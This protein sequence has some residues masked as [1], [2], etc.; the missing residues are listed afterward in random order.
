MR[1][2]WDWAVPRL[3]PPDGARCRFFYCQRGPPFR[4][5]ATTESPPSSL[6]HRGPAYP[7]PRQPREMAQSSLQ[8]GVN[9]WIGADPGARQ[10]R[11]ALDS[12]EGLALSDP[13]AFR[14]PPF[15]PF[16]PSACPGTRDPSPLLHSPRGPR[17]PVASPQKSALG[18][19]CAVLFASDPPFSITSSSPDRPAERNPRARWPGPVRARPGQ[20]QAEAGLVLPAGRSARRAQGEKRKER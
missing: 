18:P 10:G 1:G 13:H 19:F 16:L 11:R 17:C 15:P 5:P 4:R 9:A 12:A 20:D 7:P 14:Q 6:C 2:V 8:A 3:L